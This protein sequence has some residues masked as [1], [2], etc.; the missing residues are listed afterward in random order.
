M[1]GPSR[2]SSALGWAL[3]ILCTIVL[4]VVTYDVLTDAGLPE[5][6]ALLISGVRPVL[7]TVVSPAWRRKAD[8]FAIMT[9][10]FLAISVV[11]TVVGPHSTRLLLVKDSAVTGLFGVVRLGS[12][13]APRPLMFWFGRRFGTD[14]TK[15]GA[16]RFDGLWQYAGFRRVMRTMTVVWGTA[17]VLEALTRVGLSYRLSTATM[18]TLNSV[19]AYA[20]TALLVAWTV[21]YGRRWPPAARSAPGRRRPRKRRAGRRHRPGPAGTGHSAVRASS[22]PSGGATGSPSA[23]PSWRDGRPA[24][25][26]T[27]HEQRRP[28]VS[29]G[30]GS[31]R[32]VVEEG[33]VTAFRGIPYAASPVGDLRFGAPRPH[34]G[35]NG[36]RDAARSGPDAPQRRSR[37]EAVLGP[38]EPHVDE[39]GCLNLNVWVPDGAL[40]AGAPPRP[41][42][43]WIH[44]GGF[45]SGGGGWDLYDGGRLAALGGIVVVTVNYR[46]GPLGYL[47]LPDIGADNPGSQDQAAALRWVRDSVAAFGGDPDRIT[48][49]GQSAGAYSALGLALDPGTRGM[50]RGVIGE[51]GPWALEPQDPAEAADAA[52]HYLRLAGVAAASELRALPVERLLEAYARLVVE[53]AQPGN[54]APPTYPVR[55]GA[56]AAT[57]WREAVT[58][59]ALRG[60]NVLLGRTQDEMTAFLSITSFDAPLDLV[61]DQ[62]FGAGIAE[63]AGQCARDGSPAYVYRFTR[64][65]P[66]DGTIGGTPLGATHCAELPFLFNNF[67]SFRDAPTLG[68]VDAADLDLGRAFAGALAAFT[69]TGSPNGPGLEPWGPW[70]SSSAGAEPEPEAKRFG[71]ASR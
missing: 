65:T 50:V 66:G 21:L 53:R 20:V 1:S 60:T 23:R 24:V 32:G 55:G 6:S 22:G 45:T 67:H 16:A 47:H 29:T 25:M 70:E 52:A 17:Y 26:D 57:G 64:R 43:F 58:G 63:I 39:A 59:G 41:V 34:P 8:E 30:S 7:G 49:G 33:G 46:L 31:V 10:I 38:H 51:S 5:F 69:A 54:T 11:V 36:V 42:L 35:W 40:D 19:L 56:L 3:T 12:L 28:V 18:V 61:A 62:V 71:P 48:V 37:M 13:L 4:P 15:E 9:L 44:G 2:A 68:R 27:T 14:G